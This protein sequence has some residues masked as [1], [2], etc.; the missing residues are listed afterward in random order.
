MTSQDSVLGISTAVRRGEY[1]AEEAVARSID[2][3]EALQNRY[4]AFLHHDRE[5][6]ILLARKIDQRRAQ[7]ES[8]GRGVRWP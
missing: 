6:A 1:S 4:Q 5:R 7:G 3:I 8:L 2:R